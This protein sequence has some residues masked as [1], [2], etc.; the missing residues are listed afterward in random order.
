MVNL[1][2]EL[3]FFLEA[4]WVLTPKQITF[5]DTLLCKYVLSTYY[6]GRS[7]S[8]SWRRKGPAEKCCGVSA[9]G[10]NSPFCLPITFS[11]VRPQ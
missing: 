2:N 4:I 7:M 8:G 3:E 11:W 5:S 1:V 10:L 6:V 9:L